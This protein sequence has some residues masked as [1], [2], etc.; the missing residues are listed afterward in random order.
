MHGSPPI[1]IL[2]LPNLVLASAVILELGPVLSSSVGEIVASAGRVR[3]AEDGLRIAGARGPDLG[4]G[5]E[6]FVEACGFGVGGRCC[7]GNGSQGK[8]CQEVLER[9]SLIKAD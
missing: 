5:I 4:A 3:A 7:G 6:T 2:V 1:T 9:E 8:G